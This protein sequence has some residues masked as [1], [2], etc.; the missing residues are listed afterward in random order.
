MS[1]NVLEE[2]VRCNSDANRLL[3]LRG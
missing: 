1:T 2:V 3:Q